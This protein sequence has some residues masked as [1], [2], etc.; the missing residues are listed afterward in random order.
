MQAL[1]INLILIIFNYLTIL[2]TLIFGN[3]Q[4]LETI[5]LIIFIATLSTIIFACIQ[6]LRG[7]EPDLPV[8]SNSAKIQI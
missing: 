1:L 3:L 7:L 5:E 4:I 2:F 6:S 8:I